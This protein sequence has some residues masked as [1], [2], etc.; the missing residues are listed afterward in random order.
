SYISQTA[1]IT[2]SHR[3]RFRFPH[4]L[5]SARAKLAWRWAIFLYLVLALCPIRYETPTDKTLDNSWFF[6]LNYAAAHHL[7]MGR[8]I[9]WTWGPLYYLLSP[10]DIETNLA[11]GLVFQGALWVLLIVVLWDLFFRGVFPLR[12]LAV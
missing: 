8:N 6:A 10:F 7:V 1:I 11:Q 4:F 2:E 5:V 3:E 9:V 12:N